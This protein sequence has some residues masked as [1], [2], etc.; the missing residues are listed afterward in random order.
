MTKMNYS[1][2]KVAEQLRMKNFDK[3]MPYAN[4]MVEAILSMR[5]R[6]GKGIILLDTTGRDGM[7]TS[8]AFVNP[9]KQVTESKIEVVQ[10]IAGWGIPSIEEGY[11]GASA[12]EFEAAKRIVKWVHEAG[13]DTNL[14]GLAGTINEHIKAAKDAGMDEVHIFSSGSLPHAWTKRKKSPE[15]CADD[16][17]EAVKYAVSIGFRKILVSLEDAFSANPAFIAQVAVR[18]ADAAKGKAVVRYNIPDTIGV[19]NPIHAFAF[20]SYMME[21]AG[22]P[23][24]VH[25]HNDGDCATINAIYAVAAGATRV[26]TTV[27]GLGERA[28]NT[29]MS[30]FLVQLYQHHRIIPNDVWGKHL[31]ISKLKQ[32]SEFVAELSGIPIPANEVGSGENVFA[33]VSGIHA[34]GHRKSMKEGAKHSVY[35]PVDPTVYGNREKVV[36]SALAGKS[37]HLSAFEEIGIDVEHP[38]IS[39]NIGEIA[40]ADKDLCASKHVSDAEYILNAFE[41]IEGRKC[42]ALILVNVRDVVFRKNANDSQMMEEGANAK[43]VVELDGEMITANGSGNGPVDAAVNAL[44]KAIGEKEALKII[45][46]HNRSIGKGSDASAEIDLMVQDGG[47]P[48]ETSFMGPNTTL[49]AVDAYVQAY[50]AIRALEIL[51][52]KYPAKQD[53]A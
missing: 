27:N 28:G 12:A 46:Y 10:A 33:H 42:K 41:K 19:S 35:V 17:V 47:T 7:Q 43:I 14:I 31:D 24:D 3:V 9:N 16:V 34:D 23:I 2:P 53:A 50:N 15:A 40:N 25:F 18:I 39:A 4:G 49:I 11:P 48:M 21:K 45:K 26:H 13:M 38:A 30:R 20:T 37:N 29:S 22:I 8:D 32:M 52:H 44:K 51:R 36:R 5:E 1:D 6:G